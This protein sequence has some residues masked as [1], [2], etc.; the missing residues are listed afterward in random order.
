MQYNGIDVMKPRVKEKAM[1]KNKAF[2]KYLDTPNKRI[3]ALLAVAALAVIIIFLFIGLTPKNFDFNFPRRIKKILAMALTGGCIAFTSVVFQTI[4]N[5]RV[6]TPSVLG[7]DS[8]YMFIQTLVVYLF[9]SGS[10]IVAN[11]NV[12]FLMSLLMMMGFSAVLY[13]L[14]FKRDSQNVYFLLLVGMIF[15]SFFGSLSSFMQI[16]IDPNE[17]LIIQD[18]MFASFSNVNTGILTLSIGV[19]TVIGVI[20]YRDIKYLDVMSLGRDNAI[21]LGVDYNKI[22]KKYLAIVA[23]LVSISTALVGPITFLGILVVN[24]A[25]ELM[26]TYKH[27]YWFVTAILLSVV[28]LVG[29][30]LIVE[31]V[32]DF[33]T[34]LSVIINFLGGSY[35]IYLL[36][37]ESKR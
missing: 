4:T 25:K 37:K 2:K 13:K 15:G 36:L 30:Q 32:F 17:F 21:N 7:L 22:V 9:G 8:L 34:N 24:L 10:L 31:R 3:I 19:I 1:V 14:M 26:K 12:N 11:K 29:G 16:L 28:S 35:F 23:V 27:G 20:A 5:N 33:S 6:L 18:K